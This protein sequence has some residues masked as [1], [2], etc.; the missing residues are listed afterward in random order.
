MRGLLIGVLLLGMTASAVAEEVLILHDPTLPPTRQV[1]DAF[2]EALETAFSHRGPRR[3]V[4][5][6]FRELECDEAGRRGVLGGDGLGADLVFAVGTRALEAVRRLP[7]PEIPVVYVL[8]HRPP[9]WKRAR[10]PVTGVGMQVPPE[11]WIKMI[12]EALPDVKRLGVFFDPSNTGNFVK[13]AENAAAHQ[14]LGLT[15]LEVRS[16]KEVPARLAELP[17]DVGGLWMIPDPT[18]VTR[19]TVESLLLYSLR[20]RMPLVTFSEGYLSLGATVAVTLD[21]PSIGRQAATL[22]W[23]ILN[24]EP[25]GNVLPEPPKGVLLRVN[26]RVARKLGVRLGVVPSGAER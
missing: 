21:F 13:K 16:P 4:P 3:L 9:D 22:A 6:T 17:P 23:R 26:P 19:E 20:H 18:V 2:K 10:T 7:E 8:V 15:A 24:G 14:G 11:R 5:V 12:R 25:G 1:V